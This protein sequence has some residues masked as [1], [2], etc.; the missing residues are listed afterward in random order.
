MKIFACFTVFLCVF[1]VTASAA[2]KGKGFDVIYPVPVSDPDVYHD[3]GSLQMSFTHSMTGDREAKTFFL[4]YALAK[5]SPKSVIST[6]LLWFDYLFD[7]DMGTAEA[8]E[9]HFG[10]S[11]NRILMQVREKKNKFEVQWEPSKFN[12]SAFGGAAIGTT[13]I[14][15]NV[16]NFPT[17]VNA[18]HPDLLIRR[19][20]SRKGDM[21]MF[22]VST[23]LI[24][25]WSISRKHG[26]QAYLHLN[27]DFGISEEVYQA[28][29]GIS[30]NIGFNYYY[31]RKATYFPFEWNA[32]LIATPVANDIDSS[33]GISLNFGFRRHW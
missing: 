23:G 16:L 21:T 24:A 2:P 10:L 25:D 22:P 6:N 11:Y 7:K 9:L 29:Q 33:I 30:S 1:C 17:A 8:K 32:G 15:I 26:M 27:Y 3:D 4:S 28:T 12:L 19:G 20:Q 14:D 13:E 31:R 18:P 5:P